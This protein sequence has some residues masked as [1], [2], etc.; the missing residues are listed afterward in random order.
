MKDKCSDWAR[1]FPLL[2]LCLSVSGRKTIRD[3]PDARTRALARTQPKSFT[4]LIS[5]IKHP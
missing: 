4:Y 5:V 1:E 2:N 3:S